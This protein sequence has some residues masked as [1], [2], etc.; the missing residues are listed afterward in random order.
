MSLHPKSCSSQMKPPPTVEPSPTIKIPFSL[1]SDIWD[2]THA[3]GIDVNIPLGFQH[4]YLASHVLL[5]ACCQEQFVHETTTT[6]G[7]PC[8][9]FT[10]NLVKQLCLMEL[11]CV[12][13]ADLMSMLPMMAS[14]IP[15]YEG[16]NKKRLLFDGKAVIEAPK[17]FKLVEMESKIKAQA[18]TIHGIMTGMMFVVLDARSSS[19]R[20]LGTLTALV[21]MDSSILMHSPKAHKFDIPCDTKAVVSDWNHHT[22]KAAIKLRPEDPVVWTLFRERD[23]TQVEGILT[24]RFIKVHE[25]TSA[26]IMV[27]QDSADDENLVIERVD[28]FI[29]KYT[30]VTIKFNPISRLYLLLYIFDAITQFNHYLMLSPDDGP[31]G[32]ASHGYG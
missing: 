28:D 29:P 26:D 27:K 22:L 2:S 18:G 13:Y 24:I 14:Q 10:N 8:G 1:D 20:H 25:H 3:Q 32:R 9:F 31:L 5:T 16:S 11:H 30:S 19:Y 12:T 6:D 7:H 21:N 17:V 15:Q 4:K 23:A